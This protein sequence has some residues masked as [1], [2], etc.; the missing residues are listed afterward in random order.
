MK[1]V[2]FDISK[3]ENLISIAINGMFGSLEVLVDD[4]KDPIERSKL[5]ADTCW[6]YEHIDLSKIKY[7]HESVSSEVY[8]TQEYLYAK[9]QTKWR[10]GVKMDLPSKANTLNWSG[11][12][13][14]TFVLMIG[15]GGGGRIARNCFMIEA[16]ISH[17]DNLLP[18]ATLGK[19]LVHSFTETFLDGP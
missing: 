4:I 16:E 15:E 9:Y 13:V 18:I 7:Y 5:Y 11:S 2:S 3:N 10:T 17:I 19:G 12:N 8:E 14:C 6:I 1:D